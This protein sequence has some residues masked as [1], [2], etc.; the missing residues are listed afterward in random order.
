M[1][2]TRSGT[3]LP[4]TGATTTGIAGPPADF[5][6]AAL[7]L[8]WPQAPIWTA[9][10]R[11]V[12]RRRIESGF[13]EESKFRDSGCGDPDLAAARRSA[14]GNPENCLSCKYIEAVAPRHIDCVMLQI[15]EVPELRKAFQTR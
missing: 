11:S 5:L 8:F 2:S 13:I 10:R 1:A 4:T 12:A 6:S 14:A 3:V 15:G 7:E 9:S